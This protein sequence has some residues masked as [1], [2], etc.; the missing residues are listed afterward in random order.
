ML[1]QFSSPK[2]ESIIMFGDVAVQLIRM[3]GGSGNIPGAMAAKD[4]PGALERL[5]REL[6]G[7]ATPGK[8]NP[9]G[10]RREGHGRSLP[11]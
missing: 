3:L 7:A 6:R 10:G 8:E 4:V 1:V 9:D 5:N 2:T 11:S